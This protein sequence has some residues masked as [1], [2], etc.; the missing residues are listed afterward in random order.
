MIQKY[1]ERPKGILPE[2]FSRTTSFSQH[3]RFIQFRLQP[4]ME[5]AFFAIATEC[6][7]FRAVALKPG[8]GATQMV[9]PPK[10][11]L[12]EEPENYQLVENFGRIFWIGV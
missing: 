9:H 11:C 12:A 5:F 3:L 4:V 8:Y 2:D 10:V 6:I 7:D 1:G